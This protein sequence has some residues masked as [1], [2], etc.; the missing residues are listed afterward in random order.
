MWKCS[1]VGRFWPR[2]WGDP[3]LEVSVGFMKSQ[4]TEVAPR[5]IVSQGFEVVPGLM[6]FAGSGGRPAA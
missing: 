3:R 4:V 2:V 1:I 5:F 6:V